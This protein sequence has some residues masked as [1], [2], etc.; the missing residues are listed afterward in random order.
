MVEKHTFSTP[1]IQIDLSTI[2]NLNQVD[3]DVPVFGTNIY[4]RFSTF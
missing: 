4:V 2:W 3:V 1:Y